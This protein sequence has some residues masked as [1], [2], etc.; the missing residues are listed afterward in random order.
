MDP[1]TAFANL[2]TEITKLVNTIMEGQTAEQKKIIWD[3][4]IADRERL[5]KLF[6][7]D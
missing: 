1:I 5:R 4:Y 3:W 7:I 6:H 2:I